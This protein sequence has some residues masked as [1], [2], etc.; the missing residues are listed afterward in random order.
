[1]SYPSPDHW[2]ELIQEQ[3]TLPQ[4][5]ILLDLPP[6]CSYD[7]LLGDLS[8]LRH[9]Q[10]P[11]QSQVRRAL[12]LRRRILSLVLHTLPRHV[13]GRSCYGVCHYYLG[14]E[15]CGF[16]P[17]PTYY[18]QCLVRPPLCLGRSKR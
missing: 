5:P 1:M 10:P 3:I 13:F 4:H 7:P 15:I 17:H 9:D 2:I 12:H 11:L 16:L 8:L 18:R 14:T 6:G